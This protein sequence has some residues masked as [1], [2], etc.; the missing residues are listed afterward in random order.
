MKI[1]LFILMMVSVCITSG[2]IGAQLYKMYE[3]P[4]C[5]QQ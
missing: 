3:N 1:F 4:S 5:T 2:L